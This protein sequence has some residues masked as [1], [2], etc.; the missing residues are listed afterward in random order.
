MV[1]LNVYL[2]IPFTEGTYIGGTARFALSDLSF[3]VGVVRKETN[4][5]KYEGEAEQSWH[6]YGYRFAPL[7]CS[8]GGIR[9]NS[10][11][12]NIEGYTD[13]FSRSNVFSGLSLAGISNDTSENLVGAVQF[14]LFGNMAF[15]AEWALQ[16]G[17][18]NI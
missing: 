9:T 17:F 7:S 14:S 13:Y 11:I 1:D 12:G 4:Q 3:Q 2:P 15:R 6:T 18:S 16:I 5:Y 10:S 8:F